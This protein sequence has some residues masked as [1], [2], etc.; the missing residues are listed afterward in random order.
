MQDRSLFRLPFPT[1]THILQTS[2]SAFRQHS[3]RIQKKLLLCLQPFPLSCP[4]TSPPCF[5]H[6][7]TIRLD[8]NSSVHSQA[9]DERKEIELVPACVRGDYLEDSSHNSLQ[10]K[11]EGSHSL[12]Q[13]S[14][15]FSCQNNHM[16]LLSSHLALP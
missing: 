9:H 11:K 2:S 6:M 4:S 3:Q 7:E 8:R 5:Q 10:T 16:P 15:Q 1:H 13:I 12:W 14:K